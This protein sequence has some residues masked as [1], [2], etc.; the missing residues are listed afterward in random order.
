[1][2][3]HITGPGG[4]FYRGPLARAEPGD[5]VPAA[6]ATVLAGGVFRVEH[7]PVAWRIVSLTVRLTVPLTVK[8]LL[9]D[10]SGMRA[11]GGLSDYA[12]S[13]FFLTVLN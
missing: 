13:L 9:S 1:M 6:G 11:S 12:E 8:M 5:A 2:G 4:L 10:G 7:Y 3:A